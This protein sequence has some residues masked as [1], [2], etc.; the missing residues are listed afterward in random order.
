MNGVLDAVETLLVAEG[1]GTRATVV[2]G[3]AIGMS[4][5]IIDGEVVAGEVPVDVKDQIVA[6]AQSLLDRGKSLTV[7]YDDHQVYL[8]SL[9]PRPHLVIF[10]AVHVGQ[11]LARLGAQLGFHVT[12][13]DARPAFT[14][15]DRFPE[16][17]RLEVGWP[18]Q[19]EIEFDRRTYVV[20]L[21]HD[22]RF[23]DPLWPRLL[24]SPAPYIGAM[25]SAGT[26]RRRQERLLK[27][28]FTFDQ[29]ARIHSPVGLGIGS[30]T[31]AET[32]VA[33]M[34]EIIASRYRPEEPLRIV[35]EAT[36]LAAG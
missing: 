10:G 9:V 15:T 30:Q 27:A 24:P 33:I 28:G 34:A 21:S 31:P 4:A 1:F 29:I 18:D 3:P 2:A 8:E 12:V 26:A 16:A 7:G 5:L 23:E 20:V 13:S 35:G 6:D 32:A 14:T 25:G 22:A 19:V 17:D 11:E 36:R